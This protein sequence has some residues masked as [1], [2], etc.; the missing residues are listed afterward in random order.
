[1]THNNAS[2]PYMPGYG[3]LPEKEG[4]GL[5]EWEFVE[6]R[7]LA[8]RNYWLAS[9][10]PDGRAHVT[11]L[12][13]LWQFGSFFFGTDKRSQK[14]QNLAVNP[15]AVVHLES[16]DEV[17]ILEGQ[18]QIENNKKLLKNLA[19]KYQQKYEVDALRPPAAIYRLRLQ[20]AFAWLESDF[21][22]T[23]TRWTFKED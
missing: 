13:G 23:A 7:M 10:R 22:S 11:P 20:R 6:E 8:A 12:W 19:S 3:L 14:A 9:V 2:R 21:P 18:V 1:M 4:R 17:V 16:G 15:S 5:F